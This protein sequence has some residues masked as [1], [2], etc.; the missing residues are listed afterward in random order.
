MTWRS[1]LRAQSGEPQAWRRRSG[2][3]SAG[4]TGRQLVSG[5][6]E[7]GSGSKQASRDRRAAASRILQVRNGGDRFVAGEVRRGAFRAA[8]ILSSRFD[9]RD[10]RMVSVFA[11]SP[12][13]RKAGRLGDEAMIRG[14][15]AFMASSAAA[16]IARG[17]ACEWR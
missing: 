6:F 3:G 5:R 2:A 13:Q 15:A 4:G 9:L 1:G 7:I 16:I 14:D 11:C 12:P 10:G 8:F 17:R